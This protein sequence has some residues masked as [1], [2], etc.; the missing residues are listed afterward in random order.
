MKNYITLITLALFISCST[1]VT[2]VTWDDAKTIAVNKHM[3]HYINKDFNAM[4]NLLSEDFQVVVSGQDD[5][6]DLSGVMEAIN[7]HHTL[8]SNIYTTKPGVE[9]EKGI[10]SQT[11]SYPTGETWTQV[12]F[13]WHAT[14]NYSNDTLNNMVH[15]S[16]KW[17]GDLISEEYHFSDGT[18][19][20]N[21]LAAYT[22]SL[23]S[24][25]VE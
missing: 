8:F 9:N 16:Y 3:E 7:M 25:D 18:A 5:P 24:T 14:G 12:W 20:N 1:N 2:E 15:L 6:Y 23:A 11:I 19:F 13:I 4:K 22:A 21:E 17:N 10:I